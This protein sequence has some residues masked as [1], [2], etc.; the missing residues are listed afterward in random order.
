MGA[1]DLACSLG[2]EATASRITL[3]M[4]AIPIQ[5]AQHRANFQDVQRAAAQHAE[6]GASGAGCLRRCL[7]RSSLQAEDVSACA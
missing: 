4:P 7:R 3:Q 5:A 2:G 6:A 1:E